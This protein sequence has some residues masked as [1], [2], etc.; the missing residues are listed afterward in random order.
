MM[1]QYHEHLFHFQKRHSVK[2]EEMDLLFDIFCERDEDDWRNIL[3]EQ[4]IS[5]KPGIFFEKMWDRLN[6]E[7][8]LEKDN[9]PVVPDYMEIKIRDKIEKMHN[10]GIYHGD[11]H[12]GNIVITP[13][14]D[15]LFIDFEY[16]CYITDIIKN[17][18]V[19]DFFTYFLEP[20][21]YDIQNDIKG[22]LELEMIL[23]Y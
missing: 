8:G 7:Q 9:I 12:G 16:T 21:V 10:M 20:D 17:D 3:S 19:L 22:L 11:L 4:N 18:I 14:D 23:F 2:K 5:P 1:K 13:D 15:I 6:K